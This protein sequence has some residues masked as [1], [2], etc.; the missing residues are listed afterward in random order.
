MDDFFKTL[1]NF[2]E[3]IELSKRVISTLPPHRF[4]LTKWVSNSF[5]ILNSRRK[6]EISPR[7]VSLDLH[8]PTV[9]RAFGM[10]WNI[11]QGKLT[12]KPV[13]KDYPNTKRGIL[14]F[15]SSVFDP[16]GVLKP[17]LLE[18]K[19][20]IQEFWKLKI[21]WDEK[22]LKELES[23]W[24]LRK[25]EMINIYHVNL[26]RWYGFENNADI[27]VELNIFCGASAQT[28]GTFAYFLFSNNDYKQN[29]YSFV[30]SN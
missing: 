1:S 12:F 22:I 11:N 5:E 3:L 28:Y 21:S 20:I 23:R 17:S 26:D 6:T 4:R 14:S 7:L 30:L 10:F 25:N 19:R 27:R 13:T 16:L 18:P 15:V 29:I 24:I 2:D 8:T 9:E